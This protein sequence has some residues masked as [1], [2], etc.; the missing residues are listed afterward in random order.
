MNVYNNTAMG[1][2]TPVIEYL[3]IYAYVILEDHL[4]F[5]MQCD[6]ITKDIA[7]F[8]SFTARKF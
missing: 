7:R 6:D 1:N 5:I 8:K 3:K 2:Y 4:H